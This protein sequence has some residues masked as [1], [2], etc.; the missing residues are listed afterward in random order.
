MKLL[1]V[2]YNN[3]GRSIALATYTR[4]FIKTRNIGDLVVE[5]AG[6]G[7]ES[8]E[9]LRKRG[10]DKVSRTTIQILK[11]QGIDVSNHK[12]QYV[13]EVIQDSDLILATDLLTLAK[14]KADFPNYEGSCFL[15]RDAAGYSYQQEIFGPY[16]DSRG[17]PNDPT[18]T[19]KSRYK[20]ML[21]EI[22]TVSRRI[23]RN[24]LEEGLLEI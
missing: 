12:L 9:S 23:V 11:E 2:C 8:I 21:R 20:H 22:K 17:D 4:R 24:I 3:K 7:L 6:I 14:T 19:E 16:A 1:Y 18:C 15:A 13:G 10:I 5:S